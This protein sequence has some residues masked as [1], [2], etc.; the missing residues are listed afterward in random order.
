MSDED[1]KIKVFGSDDNLKALGELLSNETS[2]KIMI[3]L[4]KQEMYTNEIS[5]KLDIRISLVIHHLKKMEDLGLVEITNKKIVKKGEKHRFF[6]I[7]SD[8]FITLNNTKEKIKEKGIL[9]RIFSDGMKFTMIGVT[10][11]ASWFSLTSNNV[12]QISESRSTLRDTSSDILNQT[13]IFVESDTQYHFD[14]I[15]SIPIIILSCC[16]FL[17]WFSRKHK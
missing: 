13:I 4:M 9:K 3:H 5:T 14:P 15:I 2:R 10:G 8:L 12:Q 16:L 7:D 6:K 11:L 1:H 17:F